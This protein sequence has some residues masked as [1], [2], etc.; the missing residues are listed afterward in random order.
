MTRRSQRLSGRTEPASPPSC[1]D[2]YG[3]CLIGH[4]VTRYDGEGRLLAEPRLHSMTMNLL[5]SES[6]DAIT[7]YWT[8]TVMRLCAPPSRKMWVRQSMF[9]SSGALDSLMLLTGLVSQLGKL[10]TASMLL[11][12]YESLTWR[13]P[14]LQ[15]G[16]E[17][18]IM[19]PTSPERGSDPQK[20]KSRLS[21]GFRQHVMP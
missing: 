7:I 15:V 11:S 19:L 10:P 3:H 8:H 20:L 17:N 14:Q 16:F 18:N 2:S 6:P 12:T 9:H 21:L 4:L 5:V 13:F 1:G